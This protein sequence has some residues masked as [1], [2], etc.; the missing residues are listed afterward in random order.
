MRREGA[1]SR[2][3][4]FC[5]SRV[6]AGGFGRCAESQLVGV[7]NLGLPRKQIIEAVPH[8]AAIF[9]AGY[10]SRGG[11][12]DVAG[13]RVFDPIDRGVVQHA[14]AAQFQAQL[15]Q[16]RRRRLRAQ[17]D[18]AAYVSGLLIGADC[19]AH[20]GKDIVHLLADPALGALYACAIEQLGGR[21]VRID[22][23]A[24]FIAGATRLWENLT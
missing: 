6:G 15:Q 3:L 7:A 4:F 21:A 9:G 17:A 12:F 11:D 24:A 1:A 18:A 13:D 23:H 16:S 10:R 19:A 8:V 5:L 14:G 2:P 20:A 22:S